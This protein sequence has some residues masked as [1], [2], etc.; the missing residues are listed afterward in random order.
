[1]KMN[2]GKRMHGAAIVILFFGRIKDFLIP[3]IL[4]FVVGGTGPNI[5]GFRLVFPIIL[6]IMLIHSLLYWLTY[7]YSI[8]EGELRIK[9]GIFIKKNRYIRRHRVQSFDVT[10]GVLQRLFRLVKVRIETAGGGNEPEVEIVAVTKGEAKELRSMLLNRG[11]TE[12]DDTT[13]E[14]TAEKKEEELEAHP[15]DYQWKLPVRDLFIAGL[16]SGGVGLVLSAVLALFTQVDQL[17][18]ETFYETTLGFFVESS[19]FVIIILIFLITLIAWIISIFIT[20]IKYGNFSVVKRGN[21]LII[22]RGL[23]ETRQLTL[24]I[25][26]ITTVR[27]VA[28]MIRQPL[29]FTS[30]YV[31]SAGGGSSDEQLSTLLLPLVRKKAANEILN[32][33][34]PDYVIEKQLTPLP[35]RALIRFMVRAVI[36]VLIVVIPAAVWLPFGNWLLIFIPVAFALGWLRYK[37]GGHAVTKRH[38]IFQTRHFNLTREVVPKKRIQSVEKSHSLFQRRMDLCTFTVSILST[39]GGKSF[40]VRDMAED[41]GNDL[42]QWYS[43]EKETQQEKG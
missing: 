12:E 19:I 5:F 43:F 32:E 8:E 38:V 36:P 24:N 33:I 7:R 17:L 11:T 4:A 10:A 15:V 27:Y 13:V 22:S 6:A 37:D 16:T 2:K 31:E 14:E 25:K 20:V 39:A 30:V 23:L 3:L 40:S 1:M 35:K 42:Y 9:Q 41:D 29:G 34:V 26:R 28:T 18:P 21:D